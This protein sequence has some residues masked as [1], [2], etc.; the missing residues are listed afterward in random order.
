MGTIR[1]TA[2]LFYKY[3]A[4]GKNYGIPYAN[5]IIAL[6]MLFFLNILTVLILLNIPNVIPPFDERHRLVSFF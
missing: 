2:F 5:T 6:T 1:F 3:Y 4:R